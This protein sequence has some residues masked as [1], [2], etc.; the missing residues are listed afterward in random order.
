MSHG[1]AEAN[2]LGLTT[3]VPT[4]E[5]FLT[6]GPTRKLQLGKRQIELKHGNRWQLAL[7]KPPRWPGH[8]S[9]VMAWPRTSR[10]SAEILV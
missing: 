1:A 3:Q 8:S 6:S 4:R 7:G 9:S 10:Y 2:A 5:V